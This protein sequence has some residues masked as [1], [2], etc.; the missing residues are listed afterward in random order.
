MSVFS[1]RDR[2]VNYDSWEYSYFPYLVDM[3][4]IAFNDPVLEPY[5]MRKFFMF[6][7]ENS[8]GKISPFLR[9]MNIDEEQAYQEYKMKLG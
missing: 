4:N 2:N 1:I 3:Y 5:C 8:S 7:F 9:D 6:L